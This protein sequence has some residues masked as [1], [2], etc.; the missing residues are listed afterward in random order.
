[1]GKTNAKYETIDE[2]QQRNRLETDRSIKAPRVC[3]RVCV[4]GGWG[5]GGLKPVLLSRHLTISPDAAPK[6]RMIKQN[7]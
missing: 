7:R 3:V 5:G 2:L 6:I 4:G 1:M